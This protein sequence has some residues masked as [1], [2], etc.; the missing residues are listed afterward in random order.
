MEKEAQLNVNDRIFDDHPQ[1]PES[2]KLIILR[3]GYNEHKRGFR[4]NT[5]DE[6]E[7]VLEVLNGW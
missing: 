3:H 4:V 1:F 2:N 6:M 7:A 5:P